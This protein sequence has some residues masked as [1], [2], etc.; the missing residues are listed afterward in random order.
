MNAVTTSAAQN[1]EISPAKDIR[2]S[3]GSTISCPLCAG[4]ATRRAFKD[5]GCQVRV[6]GLCGLFFVH[7]HPSASEQHR[8]VTRGEYPGIEILDCARRYKG[9]QLYY[10]RHFDLIA[11]ECADITSILDVGSG[12]GNL[13]ERF[14]AWPNCFRLGV[15]L[16][17]SVAQVARNVAQCD[18]VQAPFETFRS[19]RKFDVITMINVFSH[20]SSLEAMFRSLRAA[21]A[22][23]GRV[24][25]RT[26]EMSPRISRWNQIHWGVPDD[27]HFLG[28]NT[29]DYLCTRYGFTI[30][31]R[32]R[33]PFEDELFLRS[34]W[35]QMGRSTW[36]NAIKRIGLCIP[37]ALGIARAIYKAALGQRL[38]VSFIVLTADSQRAGDSQPEFAPGP[39]GGGN[40]QCQPSR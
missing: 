35:Q 36:H 6:C 22:P 34:R 38:F 20:V 29:L 3:M 17:P 16:N 26:T 19:D 31:R 4:T 8:R 1:L 11:Q 32:I 24:I 40:Q 27:L 25:L 5:G 30:A 39:V 18:I 28:L 9:E 10:D 2:D 33:V 15:E 14:A 37:G 13:L 7:P 12:T 21:L 23:G